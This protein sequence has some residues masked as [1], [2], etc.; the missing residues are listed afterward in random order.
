MARIR[1]WD[2]PLRIFHWALVAC[3]IGS[4]VTENLGGNAMAWHGRCGLAILGLLTFRLVWGFVGP[5]TAR[6]ASFLRGP[7]AIRDYLQGRWQGIG[8]N[9]LGALS[10]VALLATLLIMALTGL[11][12]NDDILFDGPLYGLVD[13]ELSDQLTSIHKW[14][15]T[16]ILALVGLHLA[17]IVFYGWVKKQPLVRTMI[18]GWKEGEAGETGEVIA[19][20]TGGG[21]LAFLFAVAVAVAVV[22][23]A[24]GVWL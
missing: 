23:A 14:F 11:F 8:H 19:P 3:V 22:V 1:V 24:K 7:R 13:K 2:L 21:P 18:T 5:T 17:A 16:V 12:A 6:F 4:F 20:S 9:P 10:V 15:E